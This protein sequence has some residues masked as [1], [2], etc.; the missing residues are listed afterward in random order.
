MSNQATVTVELVGQ[1]K[2]DLDQVRKTSYTKSELDEKLKKISDDFAEMQS[3]LKEER[4]RLTALPGAD[5]GP[6]GGNWLGKNGYD[7][8]KS[9]RMGLHVYDTDTKTGQTIDRKIVPEDVVQCLKTMDE[10]Y[11]VDAMMSRGKKTHQAWLE[12]KYEA[13]KS[14][15]SQALADREV[16]KS[17][18]PEL[19]NRHDATIKALASAQD[20]TVEEF[21]T[22]KVMTTGGAGTGAEWIPTTFSSMLLDVIRLDNPEVNLIPHMVQPRNPWRFPILT[23]T[24]AAY[25]KLENVD[26]TESDIGTA[27]RDWEGHVHAVWHRFTD[28][29]DQDSIV[30]IVPALRFSLVRSMGE[31]MGMAIVNGDNDAAAHIDA[32]YIAATAPYL[33]YQGGINGLRQFALDAQ[34]TG[35]ASTTGGSGA[36][37]TSAMV[38]AGFSAM[39]K[40][41]AR[42]VGDL[43]LLVNAETYLK[44]VTEADSPVTT[45]DKYGT[46]ATILTGELARIWN[47]PIFI[48]HA[49]EQRRNSVTDEGFNDAA[50]GASN[51]L[52]TAVLFNRFNFR[53]GDL[54]DFRVETDRNIVTMRDDMV[55]SA[56]ISMN[57]I[58]GDV[59]D[60][61]WD[62]AGTPAVVAIIDIN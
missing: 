18:F 49:V 54:R 3:K 16:F 47:I 56:R 1:L 41:A 36:F 8:I 9:I 25:R 6:S 46:Q 59:G 12:A 30:A 7:S 14:A 13:R 37:L 50:T 29:L 58:E 15:P 23:T 42:R 48:S 45:L 22:T 21:L 2:S 55:A 28:E 57:A 61:N 26:A 5:V 62:P 32:D 27:N 52:S 60:A 19:A 40:F 10:V 20:K 31:G 24:G 39:G 38:A 34:G 17:F 53:I 44:L 4:H 11:L 51:T 43:A 35:A 33:T